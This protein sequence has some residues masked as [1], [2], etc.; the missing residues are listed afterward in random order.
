MSLSNGFEFSEY[1]YSHL[2]IDQAGYRVVI[3]GPSLDQIIGG[4][5]N[6][7]IQSNIILTDADPTKYDAVIFVGNIDYMLVYNRSDQVNALIKE[8]YDQNSL[9]AAIC[10]GVGVLSASGILDGKT[11]TTI[12]PPALCASLEVNG[13]ICIDERVVRDGNIITAQGPE[14]SKDFGKAILL[15]LSE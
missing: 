2:Y 9:V 15:A 13:A 3:A 12:D 5:G 10:G 11:V 6:T 1:Y 7:I 8:F 4:D 14:T